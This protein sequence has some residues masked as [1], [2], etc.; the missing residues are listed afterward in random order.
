MPVFRYY[1][2]SAVS[3]EFL[4]NMNMIG[5]T[6]FALP[7]S[8]AMK[9]W[10]I[11]PLLL[12]GSTLHF[13]TTLLHYLAHDA[14]KF[15]LIMLGQAFS[16]VASATILQSAGRL[17]TVWFPERQRGTATAIGVCA[18]VMGTAIGFLLPTLMVKWSEDQNLIKA[19]LRMFFLVRFQT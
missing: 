18:N 6:I 8:Y 17:S 1:K 5:Y 7:A 9:K 10:G 12:I 2:V 3:V 15:W 14:D 16:A 11:R 13:I 19:G 4:T